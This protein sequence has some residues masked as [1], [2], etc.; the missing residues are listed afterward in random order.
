MWFLFIQLEFLVGAL[1]LLTFMLI[2]FLVKILL[3][4]IIQKMLFTL[5]SM[6]VSEY[7]LISDE[8]VTF[9]GCP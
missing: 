2:Y 5:S 4:L 7:E 8:V 1:S 6:P 3:T 9:G